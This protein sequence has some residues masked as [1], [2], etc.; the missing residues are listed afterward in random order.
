MRRDWSKRRNVEAEG[1]WI[2]AMTIISLSRAVCLKHEM[3][4]YEAV[5]SRPEVGSSKKIILGKVIN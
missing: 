3:I 2:E 4:S 5:L 1:W